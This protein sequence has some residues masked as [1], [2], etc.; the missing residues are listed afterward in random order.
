MKVPAIL[1]ST[2]GTG[3]NAA[4]L[5][6][7]PAMRDK[8]EAGIAVGAA[9]AACFLGA[10]FGADA[11]FTYHYD[12]PAGVIRQCEFWDATGAAGYGFRAVWV[13]RDGRDW[14]WP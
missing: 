8:G 4:T 14:P 9:M 13:N 5:L 1:F 11:M 2:P 12:V 6:D 10:T 7:G 3:Q